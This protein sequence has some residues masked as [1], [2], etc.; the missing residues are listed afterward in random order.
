LIEQLLVLLA[1][2]EAGREAY[3]RGVATERRRMAQDLHDDVGARLVSGLYVADDKTRP[4]LQAALADIRFLVGGLAGERI[5]LGRLLAD[6]RRE[7]VDRCKVAGVSL[8]WPLPP[9]D[10]VL[11]DYES[12]KA[13]LSCTREAFTNVFR[14]AQATRVEVRVDV[15][16]HAVTLTIE[17]DGVGFVADESERAASQRGHGLGG[18]KS[19]LERVGGSWAVESNPG[20]TRITLRIPVAAEAPVES[21]S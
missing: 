15:D 21:V 5:A 8:D 2:A 16:E 7:A 9:D 11:V 3:D 18:M 14:H 4:I 17:D 12:V 20:R 1:K 10:R 19:R 13:L 6:L